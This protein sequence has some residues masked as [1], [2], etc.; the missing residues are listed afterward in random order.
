[1]T[2]V[3]K[4][5]WRH[6]ARLALVAAFFIVYLPHFSYG[7]DKPYLELC[8][9]CHHPERIG[10][11]APP[12]LPPFLKRYSDEK[13]KKILKDGL[14][15]TQMP[16]YGE[17]GEKELNDLVAFMRRPSKVIWEKKDIL[18][19]L[20]LEQK[21]P[22][23]RNVRDIKNLLAIVE[24]GEDKV[25]VMEGEDILDRFDFRNVH[26]GI[27]YTLD[28]SRFFVPSRDGWIARYDI[29]DGFYGKI[30]ACV[31]QRNIS[32]SRDG[33][34]LIAACVLPQKIIIFD[35]EKFQYIKSFPL[36][37]KISA[38]YELYSEDSALFTFRNKPLLG[39][40]N[41]DNLT[42]EYR[43]LDEP[44]EDFF[45]EPF[46][47]YIVGTSR[48][49]TQLKVYDRKSDAYVFKYK[50]DGMPHLFS[51]SYWY[52]KGAFYFGTLHMHRSYMTVWKMYD[53]DFVKKV[54]VGGKGF[55][56][57]THANTPYLWIDNG[58]D[59]LALVDK[60][61][62]SVSTIKPVKGKRAVHTEFSGDGR[63]AYVSIYEDDGELLLLDASTLDRIKSYPISFPAGKYNF[64]GK[65]RR[66]D[67]VQLGRQVFMNR[68]WGCHHQT[69]EAFGPSFS[70]I[71][72]SR[73]EDTI[74]MYISDPERMHKELGYKRN[75]MPKINLSAEEV[76]AV[77]S[78]MAVSEEGF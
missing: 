75:S 44:F 9:E 27:K 20:E 76:D 62:L 49:G 23:S 56:V 47:R 6:L 4:M 73:D 64:V 66:Y 67:P 63:L 10:K 35:A 43:K 45:I 3:F 54:D 8:A 7:G 42:V 32:L 59:D 22:P 34:Y 52:S 24:R 58:S 33:K 38:I 71:V 19:S 37:G 78:Y 77:T 15:A 74:R 48:K 68:C 11:T 40:L 70:R 16:A 31:Y 14:P 25:W 55:L 5:R 39:T 72:G 36:K 21:T 69:K 17:L 41:T 2:G 12:L 46:E 29:N 18:S 61:D 28:G 1:M 51:S 13:L 26:G 60:K 50:I 65:L 30:R 57:R 53:W